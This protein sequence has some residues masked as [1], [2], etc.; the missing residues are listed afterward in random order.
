MAAGAVVVLAAAAGAWAALGTG[1]GPGRPSPAA[2]PGGGTSGSR[3]SS[4]TTAPALRP[5]PAGVEARWVVEENRRPGTTAW[6][7]TGRPPGT[8]AGFANQVYAKAGGQITLYVSTDAPTF[9]V[10][11]YRMGYY[12]GSGARLVWT[13][14]PV[15][16]HLQPACP[17]TP[18]VNMVACDNWSP[19]LTVT[20]TSSFVQGDYLFK[21]V[22]SGGQASYVPLTVWD[23]TS[24]ATYV[25]KNDVYTWQLWNPYGGYDMYSGVGSCPPGVYP[26]CSRARVVSYDRPYGYG[27]GAGDFLGSEY[28][29][30]RF[31]EQ[32]GLDVTYATDVNVDEDPGYLLD[33]KA[34]LS[35][36][37]DEAWALDERQ[38]AQ[39]AE[40]HG[41]NMIFFAASPVLRH[42]RPQ[43]SPMGAE[44]EVVD[45]RDSSS[46]PLNGHGNPREVTGNTWS[47][48]PANWPETPFVGEA[49]SGYLEPRVAPVPFVVADASAWI[50]KGTGLH[51]GSVVPNVID[52]DFDQV[53]PGSAPADLEVLGHSPIPPRQAETNRSAPFSDMTY[54]ADAKSGAGVFDS[55]TNSWIPKLS[56]CPAT[57]TGCPAS[58]VD[59]MTANLLA[60]FGKGPAGRAQPSVANWKSLYP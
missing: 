22:G 50:F 16:G 29:L 2:A 33:H 42:V 40:Q 7:I 17:V 36:G 48:P 8:M 46:D 14:P 13:S 12:G 4:S 25:V 10:R 21:L 52:T 54:Y 41:V 9:E 49:Y 15:A 59:Q 39:N 26:L 27:E 19:T 30:V 56:P 38:A 44:R 18:G 60:L 6:Q 47:S 23:P 57:A 5:G 32:H 28:P 58:V 37:H 11:A 24:S 20:V 31:V 55:G 51:D 1:P 34:M 43:A 3:G 45:Y 53:D 35:L